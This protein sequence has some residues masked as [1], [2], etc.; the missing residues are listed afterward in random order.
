MAGEVDILDAIAAAFIGVTGLNDEAIYSAGGGN[1]DGVKPLPDEIGDALPALLV[2]QGDDERFGGS[3]ME[4]QTWGTQALV[5]AEYKPRGERYRGLLALKEGLAERAAQ[6]SKANLAAHADSALQ[7][8]LL[9]GFGAIEGR[10][11]Q[12]GDSAPWYLVLPIT[13]EVKVNRPRTYGAQ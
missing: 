10:Q 9:T 11:W 6:F 13:F 12:R 8:F 5:W 7:S 3:G 2:L 4:R 1:V